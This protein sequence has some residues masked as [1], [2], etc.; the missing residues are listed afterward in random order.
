[1]PNQVPTVL[2]AYI[3]VLHQG[4]RQWLQQH[5]TASQLYVLGPD[6]IAEFDHLERKDIRALPPELIVQSLQAWDLP[7][8]VE[9]ITKE[10]LLALN[11]SQT[12]LIAPNED[13]LKELIDKYLPSASV[14]YD[15]IW[16]RWDRSQSRSPKDV[17]AHTTISQT[18]FDQHMMNLAQEQ[19]PKSSDWWRQIGC[20]IVKDG[21]VVLQGHNGHVPHPQM[22]YVN[23]DPRGNFHKGD[24]IEL[25][26]A[27]HAEAGLIAQAAKQGL[28]LQGAH[29]YVTTFP[30]PNCAKLVAYSGITKLYFEEGYALLDGESILQSQGV[31]IVRVTPE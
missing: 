29:L 3:P 9:V 23:G 15:S 11:S 27:L 13:E 8:P 26:T 12:I 24:N 28:S 17:V 7:F 20:V 10:Q 21:Q 22:P 6:L 5:P 14:E 18:E 1:M 31:E 25:S 4:Y 30:C 19:T 2:L 16:L